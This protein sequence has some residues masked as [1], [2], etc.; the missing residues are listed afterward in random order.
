LGGVVAVGATVGRFAL[1]T[2]SWEG[3]FA[4][5]MA[6]SETVAFVGDSRGHLVLLDIAL[7]ASP[8][9]PPLSLVARTQPPTRERVP[10]L[11]VQVVQDHAAQESTVLTYQVGGPIVL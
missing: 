5:S 10:V 7:A 1:K 11:S 6:V 9:G 3:V 8:S 4:A 2:S